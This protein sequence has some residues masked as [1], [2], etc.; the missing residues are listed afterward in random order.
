[1]FRKTDTKVAPWWI[2]P[3]NNKKAARINCITHLLASIPYQ[4]IPYDKPNLG[5][6]KKRPVGF[7]ADKTAR[8][9]VANVF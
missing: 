7:V 4:R 2:V 9:I 6:R 3:S 8:N 5:R 1:M